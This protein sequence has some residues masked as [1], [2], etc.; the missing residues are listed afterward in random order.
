MEAYTWVGRDR[1]GKTQKGKLQA[2]NENQVRS[3][4]RQQQIVA[5]SVKKAPKEISLKL[6]GMGGKV[7]ARDL[8]I[9]TR[10]FATMIDAGLPLVQCLSILEAQAENPVLGKTIGEIKAEVEGGSTYAEALTKYPK[11]F[12]NLYV[13]MIAAGEAGGIL[14]TI[15]GRLSAYMEKAMALKGKVKAA[16][17]YPTAIVGV[18]ILIVIFLLIFVIPQFAS[19]FK[20]FGAKLPTPTLVVM[21][22]SDYAKKYVVFTIPVLI[23]LFQAVKRYYATYRGRRV[24]DGLLLKFPVVGILMRKIAVAKFTRTLGT[25][26]SSGV[27]IINGL[28]ITAKTSGNA[29]VE[30]TIAGTISHIKEGQN[31]SVP[32]GESKVFPP[33]VIQMIQ[34][35]EETGSLDSMLAKIADFYDEEVDAAVEGLTSLL[36]PMIM[37]F[38]GA[39]IGGVVVAMYLP[40]FKLAEVVG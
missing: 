12:N 34:I 28:E 16:L 14:D 32:L 1:T 10:Q 17:F 5:T 35:G 3:L 15:L 2:N 8:V 31:M 39:I 6:P 33:M 21:A 22:L 29:I 11:V 20:E 9:F 38:L 30:D 19:M 18:S 13:N 23:V 36:E 40:I 4:L 24:I 27:P 37:V 25:L 26:I 7:K